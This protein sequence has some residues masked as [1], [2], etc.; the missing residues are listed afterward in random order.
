MHADHV[1]M[2]FLFYTSHCY[3]CGLTVLNNIKNDLEFSSMQ[4]RGHP[5]NMAGIINRYIK[6]DIKLYCVPNCCF[7]NVKT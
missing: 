7:D 3:F 4:N 6:V 5:D 1:C 2:F